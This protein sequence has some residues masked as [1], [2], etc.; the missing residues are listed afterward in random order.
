MNLR[1]LHDRIVVCGK[2][3][4]KDYFLFRGFPSITRMC[5]V[6]ESDLLA[7]YVRNLRGFVC[8]C[9]VPKTENECV[10][11]LLRILTVDFSPMESRIREKVRVVHFVK[12]ACICILEAVTKV[13]GVVRKCMLY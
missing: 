2:Q 7:K 9:L 10:A 4:N 3:K 12:H 8:G 11:C 13:V 1:K 5:L 6:V